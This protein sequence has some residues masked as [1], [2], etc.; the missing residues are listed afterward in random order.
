[1]NSDVQK[2]VQS[3][4]EKSVQ[5]FY[6]TFGWVDTAGAS[7]EDTL[8]RK[9]SPPYY[10][11]HDGVNERTLKCF[12]TRGGQLLMAGGGDLP[13]THVAIA[14]MFLATTLLDISDTALEIAKKKFDG[15]AEY[16]R[17]SIL[18][19]P[20]SEHYFDATYC[21]HVIYHIDKDLQEKAI[22]ELIR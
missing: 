15:Q 22:R 1:M 11:Y 3:D 7:G 20:K 2:S 21:A 5:N 16:I 9:F 18:D 4:V 14:K 10:P 17:A 19:I 13:E 12:S 8:F 6:D